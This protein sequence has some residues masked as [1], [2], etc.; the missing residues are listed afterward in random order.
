MRSLQALSFALLAACAA[1]AAAEVAIATLVDTGARVLRGAT[2]YKLVPGARVDD[3]DIIET[4]ERTTVQLELA[5]GSI[6]NMVGPGTLHVVRASGKD[7]PALLSLQR[8]WA[9]AVAKPPG[10]RIHTAA[11]DVV[12]TDGVVVVR[13]QPA[14]ELFVESGTARLIELTPTGSDGAVHD[15]K[16]GEQWSRSPTG[17]YAT[18]ARVAKTFVDA[19]PRHYIDALPMLAARFKTAPPVLAVDHEISYSEAEPWLAGRDRA[20]FERRFASRLRDPVFRRAVEPHVARYPSWDRMLHPE[21]F[22][23]KPE[24]APATKAP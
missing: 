24:A 11:A 3:G 12:A 21:K 6:V 16:R 2:W 15:A 20:A 4:P 5:A 23:P 17:A 18:T 8:A 22:A 1:P 7:A 19:M 14:I 10:V 9:K 13:A